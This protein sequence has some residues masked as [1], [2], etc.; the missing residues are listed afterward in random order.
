PASVKA[1]NQD[2]LIADIIEM[3]RMVLATKDEI[4]KMAARI[5]NISAIRKISKLTADIKKDIKDNKDAKEIK[6]KIF[7]VLDTIDTDIQNTKIKSLKTI[8]L[9][10]TEWIERQFIKAKKD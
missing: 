5:K 8:L 7:E 3:D 10:T 6:A 9:E 1:C 4:D 2:I